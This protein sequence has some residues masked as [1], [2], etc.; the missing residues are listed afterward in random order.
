MCMLNSDPRFPFPDGSTLHSDGESTNITENGWTITH[1]FEEKER[2]SDQGGGQQLHDGDD[3]RHA[4][5]YVRYRD[6]GQAYVRAP[7]RNPVID[8]IQAGRYCPDPTICSN[9]ERPRP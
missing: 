9:D 8:Q 2:G 1:N 7:R 4:Y 5:E 3:A 6:D